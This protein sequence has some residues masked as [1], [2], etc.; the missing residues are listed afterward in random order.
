VD[1]SGIPKDSF[2][3]Q[4]ATNLQEV[5]W[6]RSQEAFLYVSPAYEKIWGRPCAE[7]YRNPQ[8]HLQ[9]IHPEDRARLESE[10]SWR[11][12]H[13]EEIFVE[14]YRVVRPDGSLRRVQA[15][16]FPIKDAQGTVSRRAGVARDITEDD[17]TEE[18]LRRSEEKYRLVV[19]HANE[20]IVVAQ[21]GMV[22][23]SNPKALEVSGYSPEE[24]ARLPFIEHVHPEDRA[25]V[26]ERYQSR[27]RGEQH[28]E[29]YCF[30]IFDR[31][32]QIHWL[33][34]RAVLISWEGRPAT[35]NFLI[36]VTRRK[37]A[38]QELR[39]KEAAIASAIDAIAMVDPGGTITY[40]N[41]SFL[42]LW[43]YQS[44]GEVLGRPAASF[45]RDTAEAQGV[46]DGLLQNGSW[47]G[48]LMGQ[49]K[50]GS[51]F[52]VQVSAGMVPDEQGRPV[53]AMAAFMDITERSRLEE[54]LRQSQKME[55]LGRLAGGMAHDFNNLLTVVKGFSDILLNSLSKEDPR[56]H[57]VEEIRSAAAKGAGMIRQ[58]LAFSRT[59]ILQPRLVDL[60]E[61]VANLARLLQRLIGED[62]EM[63]TNLQ[64]GLG[65]VRADPG[66]IEQAL[67]NL[68][69]NAAD[70]M[71]GG[72]RLAIETAAAAGEEL[73]RLPEWTEG[74]EGQA[75]V[76]RVRDSGC[77][78]DEGT[79]ARIFDPFYTTKEPDKGTGLG[80]STV[81]GIVRQS[82]GT[83]GVQSAPGCGSTFSIYLPQAAEAEPEPEPLQQLQGIAEGSETILLVEDD[84]AVRALTRT[85]LKSRGFRILEAGSPADARNLCS[86]YEG[87]IELVLSDVV[88]PGMSGPEL[89]QYLMALRP[90]MKAL[91]VSGYPQ[92]DQAKRGIPTSLSPF[93]PKPFTP[94]ELTRKVRETLD[95]P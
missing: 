30:R 26:M 37:E 70:A 27:L 82:G 65:L 84:A 81:Y 51:H 21:D 33:E 87:S 2:L 48:E 35:L 14:T 24:L 29:A 72:G 78:M 3:E 75:V 16:S 68:V 17:L 88:L 13:S 25:L 64:P 55:A 93:L 90:K 53:A 92:R 80:L 40:V 39:V 36:D 86:A 76:L 45:W 83:I 20:M 10:H 4:I 12:F 52:K 41:R 59:Q 67:I 77:G 73:R 15:R 85:I 11:R 44:E 66:Q 42:N 7:L 62:I 9:A 28:P 31:S 32:G 34:I 61:V 47:V 49:R 95:T 18:A 23:L 5:F 19:E 57:D 74:K 46:L 63:L 6:L 56:R 91:Y 94:E 1:L 54:Q 8:A 60:N 38:E 79:Q 43:G 58:L 50:D 22:K 71:A 89:V 69:V